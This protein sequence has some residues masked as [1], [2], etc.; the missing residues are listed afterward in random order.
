MQLDLSPFHSGHLCRITILRSIIGWIICI[1]IFRCIAHLAAVSCIFRRR[2]CAIA[3][4]SLQ[5]RFQ[6]L[7][8]FWLSRTGEIDARAT[9]VATRGSTALCGMLF[10]V[11]K[12]L[13]PSRKTNPYDEMPVNCRGAA[14]SYRIFPMVLGLLMACNLRQH[15]RVETV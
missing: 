7:E 15:L 3:L 10:E 8:H 13:W 2:A 4:R 1:L 14:R 5:A 6:Q 11:T 9:L 12:N